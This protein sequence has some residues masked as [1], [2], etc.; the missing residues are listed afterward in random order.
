MFLSAKNLKQERVL[1]MGR[2][3]ILKYDPISQKKPES[4]IAEFSKQTE[5]V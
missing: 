4:S 2:D 3:G 5:F 1:R